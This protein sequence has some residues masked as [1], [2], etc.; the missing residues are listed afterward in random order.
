MRVVLPAPAGPTRTRRR[1]SWASRAASASPWSAESAGRTVP[2]ARM[3]LAGPTE[4]L[5]TGEGDRPAGLGE[6]Q[7]LAL[8]LEDPALRCSGRCLPARRPSCRPG[9]GVPR[10]AVG[11]SGVEAPAPGEG[12]PGGLVDVGGGVGPDDPP[13]LDGA[14]L[15]IRGLLDDGPDELGVGLV[16]PLGATG[17]LRLG[18]GG[19]LPRG[20]AQGRLDPAV[21]D[22]GVEGLGRAWSGGG[23]SLST[24]GRR[25]ASLA[26][27]WRR[28]R[29]QARCWAAST[30]AFPAG[31]RLTGRARWRVRVMAWMASGWTSRASMRQ[32]W[33]SAHG[34]LALDLPPPGPVP[35]GPVGPLVAGRRPSAGMPR[36]VQFG[37]SMPPTL[38]ELADQGARRSR[39]SP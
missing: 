31:G 19:T 33:P 9:A 6:T 20:Q 29:G 4:R 8:G 13:P 36:L 32:R 35:G 34:G 14:T 37:R 38:G 7:H 10:P 3:L 26:T 21:R 30:S 2:S 22:D 11:S 18:P 24:P 39:R 5:G 16:D 25:P 27:S 12:L 15:G 23:S 17:Q 1:R 28:G